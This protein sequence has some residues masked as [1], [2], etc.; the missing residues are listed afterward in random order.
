MKN[1]RFFLEF[2]VFSF[3]LRNK[4][5]KNQQK[6]L[7]WTLLEPKWKSFYFFFVVRIFFCCC[8]DVQNI[9]VVQLNSFSCW[10]RSKLDSFFFSVFLQ[11]Y[12]LAASCSLVRICFVTKKN[13]VDEILNGRV[14]NE[15]VRLR[16][17]RFVVCLF[18]LCLCSYCVFV[19]C[20]QT[21]FVQCSSADEKKIYIETDWSQ[22]AY[23]YWRVYTQTRTLSSRQRNKTNET[24]KCDN[25]EDTVNLSTR[26]KTTTTN[27]LK[28]VSLNAHTITSH[29]TQKHTHTHINNA[30]FARS[31][32]VAM[33]FECRMTRCLW[34]ATNWGK[35][36]HL[37][38]RFNV[39]LCNW[40]AFLF[41]RMSLTVCVSVCICTF[42]FIASQAKRQREKETVDY[43]RHKFDCWI[44]S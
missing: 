40:R 42:E 35:N 7:V 11:N 6:F 12:K 43:C 5:E 36:Q 30:H 17:L 16:V 22:R 28:W 24:E 2:I 19:L 31:A 27:R 8:F 18:P 41:F 9:L 44:V 14:S 37:S 25:T 29:T 38:Q 1:I 26:L 3:S 32:F 33:F 20:T 15:Q 21:I 4:Q 39:T 34:H 10:D 13:I 23:T